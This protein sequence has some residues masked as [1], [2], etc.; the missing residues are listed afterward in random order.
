MHTP[1][2][3]LLIALTGGIASGKSAAATFFSDLGV[4]VFDTDQIARDVVEPGMPALAQLVAAF[5]EDILDA[6]GRMDRT[7]MRERVFNDPAQ[8]KRLEAITHPAIR[9][10]LARRS[11]QAE[12][13]YQIHVIPLLVEGGRAS[14]YDRVLVVD[15][16]EEQ[17]LRRLMARDASSETQAR[18][19]L[20]VQATRQ[21]RLAIADDVIENTG[22]LEALREQVHSLH[23]SYV[24]RAA[25]RAQAP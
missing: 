20:A 23:R 11:Q 21:Q 9:A 4:P 13:P 12:G 17:Q 10:E 2:S 5:G 6:S 7:R 15:A 8:R 24:Q 25:R 16:P 3:P 22:T 19:I 1:A 18:R 14:A